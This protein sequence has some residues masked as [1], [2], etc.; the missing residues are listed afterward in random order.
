MPGIAESIF[1]EGKPKLRVR[2]S[3]DSYGEPQP[4]SD[5]YLKEDIKRCEKKIANMKKAIKNWDAKAVAEE[6]LRTLKEDLASEEKYV[7]SLRSPRSKARQ[8]SGLDI[9]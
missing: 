9:E 8:S 3:V 4:A 6:A 2:A 7:E 1:K 5:K